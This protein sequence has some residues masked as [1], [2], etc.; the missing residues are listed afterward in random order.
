MHTVKDALA[1]ISQPQPVQVGWQSPGELSQQV[2]IDALPPVLVLHLERFLYDAAADGIVKI[3]KPIQFAPELEIPL[4]TIFSFAFSVLA[5]AKNPPCPAAPVAGNSVEPVHYKLYGVL[6][7][8]GESTDS[9]HYT[10]DVL[11]PN[12]D[13][14]SGES[15]LHI[16]DEAVGA[17]RH[18]EVFGNEQ[19][20]DRCAY[21]LFYCCT[22][23]AQTL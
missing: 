21:I 5:K 3:N 2:Q 16:D 11:H 6:Y 4:G 18:E 10:V 20:D 7:H 12:R 13:G 17:V 23:S 19:V 8:H 9:G 15:W 1:H 22:A 14:G